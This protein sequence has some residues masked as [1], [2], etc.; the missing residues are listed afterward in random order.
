MDSNFGTKG[1][2]AV[3]SV[4]GVDINRNDPT[5]EDWVVGGAEV[6]VR[7][8]T[9]GFGKGPLTVWIQ[10]SGDAAGTGVTPWRKFTVTPDRSGTVTVTVKPA[11]A[12]H[13][14]AVWIR[15][16]DKAGKWTESDI[17][18]MVYEEAPSGTPAEWV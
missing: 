15:V 11:K 8:K 2:K 3:A 12:D 14:S 5:V 13:C 6:P 7:L 18:L 17:S 9:K 1:V 10:S 16:N 4:P